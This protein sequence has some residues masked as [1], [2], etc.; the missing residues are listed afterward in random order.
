[1]PPLDARSVLV[2]RDEL[3]LDRP[4]LLQ[5]RQA[6]LVESEACRWC[7]WFVASIVT[8]RLAVE[9]VHK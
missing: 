5:Q 4:P 2:D 7:G 9:P 3:I 1:V 6:A 8:S